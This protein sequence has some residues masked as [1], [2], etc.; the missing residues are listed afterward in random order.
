MTARQQRRMEERKARKE[1]RKA[2]EKSVAVATEPAISESLDW[3]PDASGFVPQPPTRAAINKQ[4]AQ[5]STGPKTP[6]GK[7]V[8]SRNRFRHGLAGQFVI[9]DWE[10]L[11]LYHE[12]LILLQEEHQPETITE[13]LLVERMAQ[14]QWLSQRAVRLQ[15]FCFH[16]DV[17]LCEEQKLMALYLRYG[18]THDRAF[19]KCLADLLK[20]RAQKSKE[21]RGFESQKLTQ[22]AETRKQQLHEVRLQ[23]VKSHPTPP[24]PPAKPHAEPV[25]ALAAPQFPPVAQDA[26]PLERRTAA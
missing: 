2:E 24:K 21:Q 14:H 19:H 5:R 18:T 20:L 8:S 10:N 15:G 26:V 3:F 7:A 1:A 12:L 17:P 25:I 4:N 11:D 16:S 13:H 9:P 6:E 22:A 23:T